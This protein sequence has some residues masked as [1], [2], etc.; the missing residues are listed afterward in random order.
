MGQR[1]GGDVEG[2]LVGEVVER[3]GFIGIEVEFDGGGIDRDGERVRES[4]EAVERAGRPSRG[5]RSVEVDG[6]G[7]LVRSGD[8]E[9]WDGFEDDRLWLG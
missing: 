9:S 1:R 7:G 2:A 3:D 6:C 4:R 8:C 5:C